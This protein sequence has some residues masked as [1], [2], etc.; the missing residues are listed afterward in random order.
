M[1]HDP[2]TAR[3]AAR[4]L[5]AVVLGYAGL[6]KI[7][8][9]TAAGHSVAAYQIVPDAAARFVGGV[10]PFVEVAAAVLLAVG[11]ATRATAAIAGTLLAV[12]IVAIG[13]VWAR[14]LSIDCGCFGGGGALSNGAQRGYAI[15]IARDLLFLAAAGILVRNPQTRWAL[16]RWVV[17]LKPDVKEDLRT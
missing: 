8:D 14:G 17:D 4:L 3:T 6:A 1:K 12:Y 10:L 5:L 11:L 13:S 15:D 2:A 9:L 16:D 7:Q